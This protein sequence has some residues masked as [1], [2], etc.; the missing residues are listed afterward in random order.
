MYKKM[1]NFGIPDGIIKVIEAIRENC[2][3]VI[4]EA[5]YKIT[6]GV[7][8]GSPMSPF[9]FIYIDDLLVDLSNNMAFPITFADNLT[10]AFQ[11]KAHFYTNDNIIKKWSEVNDMEVN[12][13]K[14]AL[15]FVTKK[16]VKQ[17]K[18]FQEVL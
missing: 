4:G 1:R 12:I 13:K 6:C 9:L 17:K 8:Q 7:P 18:H 15:M 11:G 3:T 16:N 5:Y 14:S 10:T 2:R